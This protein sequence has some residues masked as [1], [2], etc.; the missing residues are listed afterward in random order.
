M[1]IK[2]LGKIG[3]LATKI[4]EQRATNNPNW[5]V[6]RTDIATSF[7]VGRYFIN[8]Y[9]VADPV[10]L[11]ALDHILEMEVDALDELIALLA[12]ADNPAPIVRM[13]AARWSL[14]QINAPVVKFIPL[15]ETKVMHA[16]Q[17]IEHLNQATVKGYMMMMDRA[18]MEPKRIRDQKRKALKNIVERISDVTDKFGIQNAIRVLATKVRGRIMA[19]DVAGRLN[20]PLYNAYFALDNLIEFNKALLTGAPTES[21]LFSKLYMELVMN[22]KAL[23]QDSTVTTFTKTEIPD[24]RHLD[25][26]TWWFEAMELLQPMIA[27]EFRHVPVGHRIIAESAQR[28]RWTVVM[29]PEWQ[30]ILYT[31]GEKPMDIAGFMSDVIFPTGLGADIGEIGPYRTTRPQEELGIELNTQLY[32]VG[33]KYL[34]MISDIQTA[35]GERDYLTTYPSPLPDGRMCIPLRSSILR[36]L[37]QMQVLQTGVSINIL[38]SD[39]LAVNAPCVLIDSLDNVIYTYQST[40]FETISP[41]IPQ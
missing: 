24:A 29:T 19:S 10:P 16:P 18:N 12:N 23:L 4:M 14:Y 9:T 32:D 38:A 13:L 33:D 7:D 6:A 21:Q 25:N 41:W 2:H 39:V 30:R 37:P 26:L 15:R 20:S 35:I 5:K 31:R 3:Q 34:D 1:G 11:E 8:T 22:T 36:Q 27:D 17:V 28:G 40:V